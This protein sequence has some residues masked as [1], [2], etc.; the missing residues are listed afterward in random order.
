MYFWMAEAMLPK[1]TEIIF[2]FWSEMQL[3]VLVTPILRAHKLFLI[4]I[5]QFEQVL[6]D[7]ISVLVNPIV[8]AHTI[9]F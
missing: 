6:Y 2:H 4:I 9:F 1:I 5:H 3:S 7:E 8:R